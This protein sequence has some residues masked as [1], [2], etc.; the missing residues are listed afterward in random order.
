MNVIG[1]DVIQH[2][3]FGDEVKVVQPPPEFT[4]RRPLLRLTLLRAEPRAGVQGSRPDQEGGRGVV[5]VVYSEYVVIT[6][7]SG[8][9]SL[10]CLL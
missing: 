8:Y 10:A 3:D 9:Y 1:R 5:V 2:F 7:G 4:R 6:H